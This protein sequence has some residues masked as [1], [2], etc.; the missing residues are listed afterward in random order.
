MFYAMRR[1]LPIT[2]INDS[3]NAM[4]KIMLGYTP[5]EGKCLTTDEA[6]IYLM[7]LLDGVN[8][9]A[10]IVKCMNEK[11]PEILSEEIISR[12]NL[13][14]ENNIV[15]KGGFISDSLSPKELERYDRH[16]LYYSIFNN[17]A[18]KVQECLKKS[19]VMLV[20]MG[21]IGCWLSYALAGA[22]IGT[23]IGVDND[24]IESSNLTRQILYTEIDVGRYKVDV[25]KKRLEE[26]NENIK[27]IG[28]KKKIICKD[29]LL[30]LL[31]N[32][33]FLILSADRPVAIHEWVHDACKEKGVPYSNVGYINHVGVS[34]PIVRAEDNVL[35]RIMEKE[36][37]ENPGLDNEYVKKINQ[38]FQP[39]SFGPLNGLISC[40]QAMEVVRFLTKTATPITLNKRFMFDS[41]NMKIWFEEYGN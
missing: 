4:I 28:V 21:G 5:D 34:G 19:R 6:S 23:I 37:E 36:F 41:Y 31:D 40:F 24:T 8:D 20:G 3:D 1:I 18:V 16:L 25:A 9:E 13:L 17:N 35:S 22:G 27:F 29:E 15:E 14:K 38:R 10:T 39:P 12:I 30:T 7:S 11:Y 32:V 2:E 26:Y 33:D